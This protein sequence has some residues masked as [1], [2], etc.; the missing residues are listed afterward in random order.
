MIRIVTDSASD[1]TP[2]EIK[3]KQLEIVN[4][5]INF[6][7]ISYDNDGDDAS[8]SN[9]YDL[10]EK[11]D[12]LPTTSQPAPGEYVKIFENAKENKDD[13]IV[14]CLSGGLSG[15]YQSAVMAKEM[16]GYPRIFVIDSRQA[17]MALRAVV[18]YALKLRNDG[19]KAEDIVCEIERV[20]EDVVVFGAVQT[21]KYLHMGGRI[22]KTTATVG[23]LLTIKPIVTLS[24]G[25]VIMENKKRGTKAAKR[26]LQS[27]LDI[28]GYDNNYPVYF[29]YSEDFDLGKEFMDETISKYEF[30]DPRGPYGIGGTIGTHVGPKGVAVA[31]FVDKNKETL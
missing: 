28:L 5:S 24:D 26:Y 16:V 8:F 3:D 30:N 14:I 13:M 27:K 9:F 12:L 10:L 15:T 29:G 20:K 1:F 23:N 17:I 2:Q 21:L 22:S 19:L 6:K 4:L 31:F 11:A 18:D 25:A 7:D